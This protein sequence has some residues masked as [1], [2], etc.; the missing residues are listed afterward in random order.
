MYVSDDGWVYVTM[1]NLHDRHDHLYDSRT[2]YSRAGCILRF[3]E[4]HFG[5]HYS[6]EYYT[7]NNHSLAANDYIARDKNSDKLYLSL[8]DRVRAY[9]TVKPGTSQTVNND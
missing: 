8:P 5:Q 2:Y 1:E 7:M 4:S 3:K 9:D 6:L